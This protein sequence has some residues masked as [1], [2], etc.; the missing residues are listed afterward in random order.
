MNSSKYISDKNEKVQLIIKAS[1]MRFGLYGLEKTS[2]REI[3][4]DLKLSKAS[5]YY[6]F[7]D[8]ESLYKAVVEKEQGEFLSRISERISSFNEPEQ[9]LL[10]Y[11]EARLSYFRTLLNLSRLRLEAFSDLKP[12]FRQT[13]QAFK[14]KEK[15]I[16][17]MIIEKGVRSGIF[18]IENTDQT[19]DLFLDLLRALRVNL[20]NE[21]K[22]LVIDKEEFDLLREKTISLAIIFIKGL[23]FNSKKHIE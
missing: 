23:K 17:K 3:A 9:L 6:Y 7:P 19:A 18:F 21:K 15:E 14:E 4:N 12:A 11:T 10:E 5:L 1:Q 8:K 2:M 22:T 16:I 13:I 20:V